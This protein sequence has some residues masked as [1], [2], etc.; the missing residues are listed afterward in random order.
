MERKVRTAKWSRLE[1]VLKT[2]A[3]AEKGNVAALDLT[4]HRSDSV[5]WAGR[6]MCFLD[7]PQLGDRFV[8]VTRRTGSLIV[9]K[10]P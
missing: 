9:A 4:D 7:G 10:L 1:R 3:I 2:G 8:Q 5:S 6:S